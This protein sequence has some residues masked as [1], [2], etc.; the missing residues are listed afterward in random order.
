M[1]PPSGSEA[2]GAP[3]QW[4]P[5][6]CG[7]HLAG[8]FGCVLGAGLAGCTAARGEQS[9]QGIPGVDGTPAAHRPGG[10]AGFL[11]LLVFLQVLEVGQGLAVGE[12]RPRVAVVELVA[13]AADVAHHGHQE[14]HPICGVGA[15]GL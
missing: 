3:G 2:S 7:R 12:L 10:G 9:R 4:G 13:D 14:V 11:G 8:V 6:G 5:R 15:V 1:L